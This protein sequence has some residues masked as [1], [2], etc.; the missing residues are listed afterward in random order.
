MCFIAELQMRGGIKEIQR[1]VFVEKQENVSL[2]FLNTYSCDPSLEL[3]Q[4][5][6]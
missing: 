1:Y 6:L 2:N 5:I 4:L 3:S